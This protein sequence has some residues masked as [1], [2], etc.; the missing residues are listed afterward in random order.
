[1]TTQTEPEWTLD[2]VLA[3]LAEVFEE[4][5]TLMPQLSSERQRGADTPT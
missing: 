5:Q 1:M 2:V 4:L 3:E